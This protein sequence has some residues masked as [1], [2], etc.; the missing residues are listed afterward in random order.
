MV[1]CVGHLRVLEVRQDPQNQQVLMMPQVCS[2]TAEVS[3][4][5]DPALQWGRLCYPAQGVKV[6]RM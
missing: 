6:G 5:V 4:G 2:L 1:N 3:A